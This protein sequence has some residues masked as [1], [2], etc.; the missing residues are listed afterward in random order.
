M[1]ARA[2]SGTGTLLAAQ[3]RRAQQAERQGEAQQ[4]AP[5]PQGQQLS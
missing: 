1:R 4:L 2:R 5:P 3:A